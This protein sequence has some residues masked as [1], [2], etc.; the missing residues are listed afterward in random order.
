NVLKCNKNHN[1]SNDLSFTLYYNEDIFIDPRI[2]SYNN[3]HL[4]KYQTTTTAHNTIV[5]N[6]ENYDYI[7][8]QKEEVKILSYNELE[9][10][11]YLVLENS[12]YSY[13][14]II[15]H[16]FVLKLDFTVVIIDEVFSRTKVLASQF[17]N[18][19]PKISENLSL[20]SEL[21]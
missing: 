5:L 13:A 9:D 2:Y 8:N 19:S 7:N 3:H 20:K 21:N 6:N 10:Y 17:F 18:L 15:R 4:R 14:N 1:H 16:L 11:Y 12:S